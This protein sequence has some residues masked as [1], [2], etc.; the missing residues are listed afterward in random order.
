MTIPRT[1]LRHL[2]RRRLAPKEY[3]HGCT[4]TRQPAQ[5][6]QLDHALMNPVGSINGKS[7]EKVT[8]EAASLSLSRSSVSAGEMMMFISFRKVHYFGII[9]AL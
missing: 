8:N 6:R 1:W 9:I 3:S 4:L 7:A 5:P 2:G